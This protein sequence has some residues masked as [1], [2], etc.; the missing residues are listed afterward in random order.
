M[1]SRIYIGNITVRIFHSM[2]TH[3][4]KRGSTYE[5]RPRAVTSHA[6]TMQYCKDSCII[7][8]GYTK[9]RY[10]E[11]RYTRRGVIHGGGYKR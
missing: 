7:P 2:K 11:G 9:I 4:T 10:T 5:L 6:Q 8:R 1:M 3:G